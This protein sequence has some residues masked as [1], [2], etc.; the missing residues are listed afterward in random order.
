M[1]VP[2]T[3]DGKVLMIKDKKTKEWGF[4]TG[5]VKKHE[6]YHTAAIRELKEETSHLLNDMP[7][8]FCRIETKTIYRPIE[9]KTIDNEKNENVISTYHIFIYQMDEINLR[10]FKA[11]NEVSEIKFDYYL[12]NNNTWEFCND[13]YNKFIQYR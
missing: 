12:D 9:L 10:H 13:M 3:K 8:S 6:Q 7:S 1:V 2:K 5:G 4:V 11:N